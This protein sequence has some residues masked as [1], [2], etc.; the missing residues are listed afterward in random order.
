MNTKI[1]FITCVN[2]E[3][4]Y[5]ECLAK[6]NE[7]RVPKG[8]EVE[9]IAIRDAKSMCE[10]YNRGQNL[11]EARYKVYLH[12]DVLITHEE[13]ITNT[14]DIFQ[15]DAQLGILG[16]CGT[17]KLPDNAIW[18]EG[19]VNYGKVVDNTSGELRLLQFNEVEG[20]FT[21]VEAL[22]GLILMTQT[23]IPWREDLFEHFHFYDIG[24]CFEYKKAG[25]KVGVINQESPWVIHFCQPAGATLSGNNKDKFYEARDIFIEN[26]FTNEN[27]GISD[28]SIDPTK[29]RNTSIVILTYDNLVYNQNLLESIARYTEAGTYEVIFVDNASTDGTREWLESLDFNNVV[30]VLNDENVGFP[31]GCN[32]GVRVAN[33]ENDIL[34]LN[35]DIEVTVNWLENLRVALY[36]DEKIGAVQGCDLRTYPELIEKFQELDKQKM[37]EFS[38]TNNVSDPSRWRYTTYLTGYCMLIRRDVLNTIGLLDDRFSPGNFEDNDI[39]VR[40]IESGHFVLECHDCFVLHF[41]SLSFKKNSNEEYN[42]LLQQNYRKFNQKWGYDA[43]DNSYLNMPIIQQINY[44]TKENFNVL[45]IG[46]KFD[47]TVFEIK[48]HWPKANIYGIGTNVNQVRILNNI[49]PTYLHGED[50]LDNFKDCFFDYILLEDEV[51]E[52][53]N[54]DTALASLSRILKD[55]GRIALSLRNFSYISCIKAMIENDFGIAER[56]LSK[57]SYKIFNLASFE[58]FVIEQGYQFESVQ[59]WKEEA[60]TDLDLVARINEINGEDKTEVY[61]TKFYM[62]KIRKVLG[63]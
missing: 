61:T 8:I 58:Q 2:D 63:N 5:E 41:I 21:E 50:V 13:F 38:K 3:K 7:L 27:I 35:N 20:D 31:R 10:G 42:Q 16:L 54:I 23:D 30:V 34:F 40:V 32:D 59:P 46:C 47:K 25:F 36:S 9:T 22:D 28:E 14:I 60:T 24:A 15:K 49:F 11:S 53:V 17:K 37:Q 55:D 29:R 26:Y 19:D 6:I 62:I 52:T 39:S 48:N 57:S 44:D 4:K 12:Q 33:P 56:M 45:H 43:A 1:A 18:W 51:H